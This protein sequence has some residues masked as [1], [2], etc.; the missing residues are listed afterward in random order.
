MLSPDVDFLAM[1]REYLRRLVVHAVQVTQHGV[2]ARQ[3]FR[4][5]FVQEF[6]DAWS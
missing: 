6:G 4:G 1:Q 2:H 5:V 3:R